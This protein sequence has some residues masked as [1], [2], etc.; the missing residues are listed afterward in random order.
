MDQYIFIGVFYSKIDFWFIALSVNIQ[1]SLPDFNTGFFD[2]YIAFFCGYDCEELAFEMLQH[3]ILTLI[4]TWFSPFDV[5]RFIYLIKCVHEVS[6]YLNLIFCK[7]FVVHF[8]NIS[9]FN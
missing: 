9:F 5:I 3:F 6:T 2:V 8:Y 7:L 1:D 4:V